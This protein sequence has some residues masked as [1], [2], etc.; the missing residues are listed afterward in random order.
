ML[1]LCCPCGKNLRELNKLNQRCWCWICIIRDEQTH[2]KRILFY[3]EVLSSMTCWDRGLLMNSRLAFQLEVSL[4]MQKISKLQK[5]SYKKV[6]VCTT[7]CYAAKEWIGVLKIK[8]RFSLNL[9]FT[10][11]HLFCSLWVQSW[12]LLWL[13]QVSCTSPRVS[14]KCCMALHLGNT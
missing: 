8:L 10:F 7:N 9:C 4:W 11:S 12:V 2:V 13:A 6:A 5:V 3:R 14:Q 1:E